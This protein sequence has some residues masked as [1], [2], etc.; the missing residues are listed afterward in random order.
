MARGKLGGSAPSAA[1]C[2]LATSCAQAPCTGSSYAPE[3]GRAGVEGQATGQRGMQ[4][5]PG[6]CV[7]P[8]VR[9]PASA[10][11]WAAST[12][13]VSGLCHLPHTSAH[14]GTPVSWPATRE[15]RTAACACRRA[16]RAGSLGRPSCCRRLALHPPSHEQ[17][18]ADGAWCLCSLSRPQRASARPRRAPAFPTVQSLL[19]LPCTAAAQPERLSGCPCP[20]P[21][22]QVVEALSKN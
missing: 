16:G 13:V 6:C 2:R 9:S 20:R 5:G 14:R 21:W 12:R 17:R 22:P 10:G 4:G 19:L 3:D 18:L 7:W 11:D 15:P 1:A 8:A